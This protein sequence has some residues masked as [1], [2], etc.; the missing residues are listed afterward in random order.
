[1]FKCFSSGLLGFGNRSF[2]DDISIA[3]KYGYEGI[4]FDITRESAEFSPAE[5]SDLLAKNKLRNGGFSLPVDFRKTKEI[6]E[7]GLKSLKSYCDFAKNTGTTRCITW[8]SPFSDTLDYE[9]NFRLHAERLGLA[10]KMLEEYGIRFGLEFVGP[11]TL[12]K[13]KA[14]EFIHTLDGLNELLKAIGTSN[15]G[16]LL[17]VF[18]W[19]TAAQVSGDFKKIPGKEW[20][21]MVHIND[22]VKGRSLEE[23]LDQERELPGA[24]GVLKI[25]E[26][27]RGLQDMGYDGPVAV[28]PF[29]AALK[30][31]AFEEA[32]KTAKECT[33]KVWP[34]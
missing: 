4:N 21:V 28:E 6:F 2:A 31:M 23:Q 16:Y 7:E 26:F 10:A 27:F 1:M 11:A 25:N 8:L 18:H 15:M 3:V 9:S 32:V 34:R 30:A 19:D 13:G 33:D 14:H 17:D 24:T 29:N 22:G 12:R 20:V 5:F